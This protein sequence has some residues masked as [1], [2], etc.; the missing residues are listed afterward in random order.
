MS[1]KLSTIQSNITVSVKV[2]ILLAV[3]IILYKQDL[4]LVFSKSFSFAATTVNNYIFIIP[5]LIAYVLY[6]KQRILRFVA[7]S[8]DKRRSVVG[9]DQVIGITLCAIAILMYLY[10][11]SGL[12]A[13]ENHLLSLPIFVSGATILLFNIKTFRHSLFAIALLAS[14]QPP[15]NEIIAELAADLSWMTSVIVQALLNTFGMH[16]ELQATLGAPAL[17]L[18]KSGGVKF[19]FYV[20]EPSSGVYSTLGLSLFAFFVAY[21]I[22]GPIWKRAVIFVSGFPLFFILNVVRIAAIISLWDGFGEGVSESFHTIGGSLMVV[23]GTLV[24]LLIGEKIFKLTILAQPAKTEPCTVCEKNLGRPESFCLFCGRLLQQLQANF[25]RSSI[26][27]IAA[28]VLIGGLANAANVGT[29]ATAANVGT[30]ATAANVGTNATAGSFLNLDI[31]SIKGPET[32][33]FFPNITGWDI[34]YSYRDSLVEKILR[35]DAALAYMFTARDSNSSTTFVTPVLFGSVEISNG[36]HTWENSLITYPSR[37]GR[38]IATVIELSDVYI[39]GDEKARF[40]VFKRPDSDVT[41]ATL[42]WFETV[43]LRSGS[44]YEIKNILISLWSYPEQLAG[45]GL[46]KGTDDIKGI[47]SIYLSL[48]RPIK[49]Y[50]DQTTFGLKAKSAVNSLMTQHIYTLLSAVVLPASLV[51]ARYQIK[52]SLLRHAN[53]KMYERLALGEE[54]LIFEATLDAIQKGKSTGKL[55]ANSYRRLT[56]TT[57]N[58]SKLLEKLELA[59][60]VGLLEIDVLSS[61]DKPLLVWKPKFPFKSSMLRIIFA[62]FKALLASDK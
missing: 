44:S 32:K 4:F 37:V 42:F 39:S 30:N 18:E 40:F 54:K 7:S 25:D 33:I 52:A 12:Y 29:N 2:G 41:E 20:G 3:T 59:R 22:R 49:A 5:F 1:T 11:S 26:L 21:L 9:R 13:V 35:E 62:T 10:A 24:V 46:I 34:E 16:L 8:R 50:W 6:R 38:P 55:I 36:G 45:S 47:K 61:Y 27:A 56:N 17:L 31:S 60:E 48:A 28:L 51:S 23:V 14:L 53:R 57:I 58:E 15:S 19:P 43:Q